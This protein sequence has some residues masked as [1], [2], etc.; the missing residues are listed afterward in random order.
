NQLNDKDIDYKINGSERVPG[1]LNMTYPN[2]DGQSLVMQLD[3]AGIGIS[4]GA[5]C[6]SGTTKPSKMLLN[7]GITEKEA[8]STVRISFGKIHSLKDVETVVKAIHQILIQQSE[9][10][11]THEG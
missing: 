9:K 10:F 4:F 3:I 1:V 11:I 2:I 7:M 8:Q 6:A 5:A